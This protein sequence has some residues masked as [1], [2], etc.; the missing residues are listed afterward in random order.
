MRLLLF[1][2]DGT[3]IKSSQIGRQA[4]GQALTKVFGTVGSLNSYDFA[5]KTD[6]QIVYDLLIAEGWSASEIE[7]RLPELDEQMVVAGRSLFTAESIQSHP[8]IA[9]LLDSLRNRDDVILSLLTGNI[10]PSASLK[11]LAASIDPDQFIGGAFGSDSTD[12]NALFG[13]ALNRVFEETGHHFH[14]KD[15]I[16]IGDTPADIACAQ[17]GGCRV[18]A[19]AT[20]PFSAAE[21]IRH[22]PD[23]LLMDLAGTEDVLQALGLQPIAEAN[24]KK[25]EELRYVCS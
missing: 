21:L 10:Q 17:H 2:I 25:E 7:T 9:T 4:L 20:G 5:G 6:R 24:K 12:R 14:G 18:L 15:V 13:I 16:I 3:L 11:L 8:G 1:D 19:V 22:E 23:H